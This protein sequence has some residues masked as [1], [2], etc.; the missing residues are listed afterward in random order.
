[1]KRTEAVAT[2]AY[3]GLGGI[4]NY[5]IWLLT[6]SNLDERNVYE[7]YIKKHID[8]GKDVLIIPICH[9]DHWHVLEVNLGQKKCRHYS[10]ADVDHWHVLEVNLGQ[11]KCRHYSSADYEAWARDVLTIQL[12]LD[13]MVSGYDHAS[14]FRAFEYE[15]VPCRTQKGS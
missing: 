9:V 15:A 5:Q 2:D 1:M 8:E 11:K 13:R 12:F 3:A 4:G 7:N 10:S 6:A 14:T